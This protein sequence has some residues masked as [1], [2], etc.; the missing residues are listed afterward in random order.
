MKVI[1]NAFLILVAGAAA[2]FSFDQSKKF[3][4]QQDIR[5]KTTETE[6]T[7]SAEADATNKQFKDEQSALVEST[8]KRDE[9][10]Q[11]ITA[12][13]ASETSLKRDIAT[14]DNELATQKQEL[15]ELDKAVEEL[16]RVVTTFGG[17]VTIDNIGD[18]IV[19]L[20]KSV[21]DKK[22]KVDELTTL[23][24]GAQKKIASTRSESKRLTDRAVES[25]VRISRNAMEAV[26]TAVNQ[27]WGFLVIGAGSNSGFTPQ[28]SL[29]VKRDGKFIARVR[30][31][32]IE[33]T[34]TVA[35]IDLDSLAPGVRI[36]PGDRVI[37]AT[38]AA[39]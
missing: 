5:L 28:S 11:S 8:R 9:I 34:Q 39:N 36:Q 27:D 29:L 38:P 16:N 10:L 25:S 21:K 33:A 26:V 35:D 18:K 37:V 17:G 1:A 3:Q 30:P 4:D 19:E 14:V 7:T 2:Y 20:E 6:V 32:S 22:A 15:A 23:I 24:D 13:K 12:L 31:T